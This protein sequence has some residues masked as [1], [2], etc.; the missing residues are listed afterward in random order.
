MG[1]VSVSVVRCRSAD[2]GSFDALGASAGA[3]G[4]E[5]CWRKDGR[6]RWDCQ[7]GAAVQVRAHTNSSS[8]VSVRHCSTMGRRLSKRD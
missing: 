7:Q 5:I 6:G 4:D 1:D 8:A 3:P 2:L